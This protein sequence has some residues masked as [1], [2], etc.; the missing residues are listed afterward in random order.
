MSYQF[1]WTLNIHRVVLL[2]RWWVSLVTARLGQVDGLGT[3]PNALVNQLES[4]EQ[5]R[6]RL[7]VSKMYEEGIQPS[8]TWL[9]SSSLDQVGNLDSF[10]LVV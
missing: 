8:S 4:L 10:W 6:S 3:H 7:L 2:K 1:V 5:Q 9:Q